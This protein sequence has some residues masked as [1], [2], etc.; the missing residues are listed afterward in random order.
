MNLES[1]RIGQ[2]LLCKFTAG[3]AGLICWGPPGVD[4]NSAGLTGGWPG[5]SLSALGPCDGIP[6]F[7]CTKFALESFGR[8]GLSAFEL[9]SGRFD[10]NAL[11]LLTGKFGLS[12]LGLLSGRF[13]LS[14]LGLFSGRFGLT[15]CRF[16]FTA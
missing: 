9:L 5:P 11:G 1:F 13:G 10:F 3:K 12:V 7:R 14:A 2:N 6:L 8:F 4:R 16:G 15:R